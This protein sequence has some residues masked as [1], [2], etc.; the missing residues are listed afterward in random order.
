MYQP[1]TITIPRATINGET[2]TGVFEF[3]DEIAYEFAIETDALFQTSGVG[4]ELAQA[5]IGQ[6]DG[7][8]LGEGIRQTL[9][10]DIGMGRHVITTDFRAFTGSPHQWG[11]GSGN[12]LFD[13]TGDDIHAQLAVLDKYLNTTRLDSTNPAFLDI[14]EYSSDGRY[15]TLEVVPRNP[16]IRFDASSESSTADGSIDWVE[17]Q[18]LADKPSSQSVRQS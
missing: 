16:N 11:D 5:V 9:T 13:A 15:D 8:D 1:P 14:G 2:V 18:T 3:T 10:M 12:P 4:S 6:F 17:T 7:D